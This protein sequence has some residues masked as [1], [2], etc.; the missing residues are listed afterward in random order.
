MRQAGILAAAGLIALEKMP[1]R[2]GEDHANARWM[3]EQLAA[4]PG[5]SV[6]PSKV[7]TN[8]LIFDVSGT[9]LSAVEF[10]ARMEERG[11]RMI[12]FGPKLVRI[13]THYDAPIAACEI[14]VEKMKDMLRQA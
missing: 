9:P 8:I 3:A 4:M 14:A 13:V 1:L 10:A 12:A 2:L 7:E 6:D 11:V 5:V